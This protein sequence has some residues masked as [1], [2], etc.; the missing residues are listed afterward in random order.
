MDK[1]DGYDGRRSYINDSPL[2]DHAG[3]EMLAANSPPVKTTRKTR[4]KSRPTQAL[5]KR[6][7]VQSS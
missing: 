6:K 4:A 3:S 7:R 2:I 1:D 5:H